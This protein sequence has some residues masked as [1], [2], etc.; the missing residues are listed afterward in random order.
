MINAPASCT[1]TRSAIMTRNVQ[2]A[3]SRLD[4]GLLVDTL[5]E[6]FRAFGITNRVEVR[7]NSQDLV[8]LEMD[9]CE[10]QPL[11]LKNGV[12]RGAAHDALLTALQGSGYV[13]AE[14]YQICGG[15]VKGVF[16][17]TG[18]TV[19]SS[20]IRQLDRDW[21]YEGLFEQYLKVVDGLVRVRVE[22]PF[23]R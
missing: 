21:D 5:R 7:T 12:T 14:R 8:F 16:Y 18:E 17:R 4:P 19:D 11:L 15:V 13:W 22:V 6:Y 1:L 3:V 10:E 2:V 23:G 20:R 9:L